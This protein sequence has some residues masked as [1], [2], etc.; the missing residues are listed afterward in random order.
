MPKTIVQKVVFKNTSPKEL[1]DLY[2][3]AEKHSLATGAAA[4]ISEKIGAKY[5]AYDEYIDGRNLHLVKDRLIVQTWRAQGWGPDDID[6][7]FIINFHPK[8]KNVELHVI[9][10]N[11]P[12]NEF[13]SLKKGWHE[14]YWDPWKKYLKEKPAT[15]AKKIKK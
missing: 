11:V 4:K 5:T 1:Y 9:H 12:D 14:N 15:K 8:G 10:A 6:S 2:M 13:E 3:N 7:T